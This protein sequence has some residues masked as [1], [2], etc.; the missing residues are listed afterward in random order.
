M[1]LKL[2]HLYHNLMNLYGEYGNIKALIRH[3]EDQGAQV[4]LTESDS[5]DG[6]CFTDYDF[7]YIGSGTEKNQKKA[8]NDL[9]F[10]KESFLSAANGGTV[11]LLTGNSFELLGQSVTDA[12]GKKYSA[13][14]FADFTSAEQNK[15]RLTGDCICTCD[16]LSR[17]LVGFINKCSEIKG[18]S[19]PLF[20]VKMGLTNTE[21]EQTE[22]FHKNNVY[23]THL[24]GPV[25]V[26]NPHFMDE[27]VRLIC[28]KKD[29]AFHFKK[30]EYKYESR[31]YEVTLRELQARLEK[32]G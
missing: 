19:S 21:G 17:P 16:F 30:A 13:L 27:M 5:A 2:L 23:G 26:K 18:I 15:K 20:T 12:H 28:G 6:L 4:E 3:L 14:G 11:M 10:N 9:L 8:L 7:I 32:D 25:L 31:A 1:E 24:I 29:K 22:G